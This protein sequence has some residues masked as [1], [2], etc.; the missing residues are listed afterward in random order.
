MASVG[1]NHLVAG[2]RQHRITGSDHGVVQENLPT[3]DCEAGACTIDRKTGSP[4]RETR[5][6]AKGPAQC[7]PAV[8]RSPFYTELVKVTE[9]VDSG[10]MKDL[11]EERIA[12]VAKALE[13]RRGEYR[14]VYF[15][16]DLPSDTSN[17]A[18]SGT[19]VTVCHDD[20]I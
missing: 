7:A 15:A 4:D 13:V 20:Q 8:P 11:S 16:S 5:W 9:D 12:R 18:L 10:T 6:P 17:G 14:R 19:A 1:S 3:L 2:D